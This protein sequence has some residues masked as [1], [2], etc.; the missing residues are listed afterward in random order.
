MMTLSGVAEGDSAEISVC[1]CVDLHKS[2]QVTCIFFKKQQIIAFIEAVY[3]D[4]HF[5]KIYIVQYTTRVC[6]LSTHSKEP[7]RHSF[8]T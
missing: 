6:I 7:A 5:C 8:V 3:D 2:L 4:H 1:V